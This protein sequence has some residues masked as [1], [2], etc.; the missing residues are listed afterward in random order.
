MGFDPTCPA[1]GSLIC[2]MVL[3]V[4]ERRPGV[5]SDEIAAALPRL[6]PKRVRQALCILLK[7]SKQIRRAKD[8]SAYWLRQP[9]GVQ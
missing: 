6:A 9:G 8:R 7:K 1:P 2:R 5:S 3:A 4:I